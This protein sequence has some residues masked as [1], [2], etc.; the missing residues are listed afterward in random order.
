MFC[1]DEDVNVWVCFIVFQHAIVVGVV[2]NG[3]K[4]IKTN[5]IIGNYIKN[6]S[7]YLMFRYKLYYT[8]VQWYTSN[9]HLNV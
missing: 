9:A 8:I 1:V 2:W 6:Y 7:F 3:F 4:L 5:C